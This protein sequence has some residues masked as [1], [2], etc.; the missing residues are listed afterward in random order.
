MVWLNFQRYSILSIMS[1]VQFLCQ[2]TCRSHVEKI[3]RN[4]VIVPIRNT[5][6]EERAII[7]MIQSKQ[8]NPRNFPVRSIRTKGEKVKPMKRSVESIL[9][10][11]L[12]QNRKAKR[13]IRVRIALIRTSNSSIVLNKPSLTDT[14]DAVTIIR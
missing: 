1:Q 3:A 4:I 11:K 10:I 12:S 2:L 13:V 8:N 7:Q 14:E 5:L 9:I 6:I